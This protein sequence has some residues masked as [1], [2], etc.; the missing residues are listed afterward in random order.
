ML[1]GMFKRNRIP[2]TYIPDN[3]AKL[4]RGGLAYFDLLE[5]MIENA[6]SSIHF[7]FY[8]F[9]NDQT[10]NRIARALKAAALRHVSVYVLLDG[11]ASKELP[12]EFVEDLRLAGVH[13]RMFEPVLK[14]KSFYFGRRLHHK[15][16]VT[17]CWHCLVGGLNISDRYNDTVENKAWLDWALFAEGPVAIQ[18]TKVCE[19]KYKLKT[20][21]AHRIP[22]PIPL[23]LEASDMKCYIRVRT[24]DWV[25]RKWEISKSYLEMLR[26]AKTH[27]TIMSPYFLPGEL[28]RRRIRQAVKRGV[29][30][31]VIQESKSDLTLS[32]PAERY[33]YGW[34]LRNKINI[35]EYQTTML[36]GKMA[37]CDTQWVT[38]GSYNF[39]NLSAYASIELNLDV[40]NDSFAAQ[41]QSQLSE[42]IEKDCR[43]IT[44]EDYDKNTGWLEHLRQFLAY[45]VFRVILFLFTFYFKQRE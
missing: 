41:V 19:K 3:T 16:V 17:D 7:Q 36:H 45:N 35:Y 28:F 44:E 18:L 25:N 10:G 37:V 8:I 15:V 11:Y 13:L 23:P 42:I 9:D 33:M 14:S 30:I 2:S 32:K 34:L 6:R 40:R 26:T 20:G 39:N 1:P 5:R 24:N 27:I 22:E 31:N 43:Q 4:I 29:T 38:I 12:D 21:F